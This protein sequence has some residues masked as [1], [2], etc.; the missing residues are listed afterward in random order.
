MEP[1]YTADAGNGNSLQSGIV[2]NS[3]FLDPAVKPRDDGINQNYHG[4]MEFSMFFC[5]TKKLQYHPAILIDKDNI[6][7]TVLVHKD[8]NINSILV[9]KDN[10]AYTILMNQESRGVY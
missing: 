2:L 6:D 10:N 5:P 8:K 1:H 9:D 7:K 4:I 3:S